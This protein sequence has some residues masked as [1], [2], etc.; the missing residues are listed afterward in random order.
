[1]DVAGGMGLLVLALLLLFRQ[2]G[3]WIGDGL[4]WP[5]VLA[6]AGGGADLAPVR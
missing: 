3:L 2:W 1:M 4:V 5:V 6:A